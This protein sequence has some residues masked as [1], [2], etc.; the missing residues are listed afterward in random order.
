[1]KRAQLLNALK[2][3]V[4]QPTA[5]QAEGAVRDA[6]HGLLKEHAVPFST[7]GFGNTIARVRQGMPRRKIAL[8]THLDQPALR[9]V[10][11]NGQTLTCAPAGPFV[12]RHLKGAEVSFSVVDGAELKG[13]VTTTKLV[14]KDPHGLLEQASVRLADS[15]PS[16]PTGAFGSVDLPT[17]TRSGQRVGVRS[18]GGLVGAAAAVAA[19][20]DLAS[21][22]E[23]M[24]AWGIFTRAQMPGFQGAVAMLLEGK[25][26]RDLYVIDLDTVA[27]MPG[28]TLG[29]GPYIRL[30]SAESSADPHVAMLLQGA[31]GQLGSKSSVRK[32]ATFSQSSGMT[33]FI[34]FGY[35][36][37][38][39]ALPVE[40]PRSHGTK[41]PAN[42]TLDVGD[43]E[44]AIELL[45]AAVLRAGA[46]V[47]D[48]DLLRNRVIRDSEAGRDALRTPHN[49][50]TG[51]PGENAL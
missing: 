32:A 12:G 35:C 37:A 3:L 7:D 38:G 42:E 20:A 21:S 33:P 44:V 11:A 15:P 48:M 8:L 26:P 47:D 2:K 50:P 17:F 36:A 14:A 1:M 41:G 27:T 31:A 13:T 24:E 39:L 46:G 10:R 19:L 28:D 49:R 25:L 51:L 34:A 16:D 5:P 43:L 40:N 30:A 18:G 9:V 29:A 45:E 23:P 6:L 22:S 4:S